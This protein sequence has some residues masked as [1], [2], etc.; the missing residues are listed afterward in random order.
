MF[1]A[2]GPPGSTARSI[3]AR[4]INLPSFHDITEDEMDI[5]VEAVGSVG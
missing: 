3:A 1:E 2:M 5:V 4:A